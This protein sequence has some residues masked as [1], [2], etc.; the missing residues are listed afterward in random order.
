MTSELSAYTSVESERVKARKW[1]VKILF[2]RL[3]MH[4]RS[5]NECVWNTQ[6]RYRC[7]CDSFATAS[8][9]I[10]MCD[11]LFRPKRLS[12]WCCLFHAFKFQA[13]LQTEEKYNANQAN[14]AAVLGEAEGDQKTLNT[15]ANQNGQ[16]C[17]DM[18]AYAWQSCLMYIYV[19]A[20][21]D[22]EIKTQLRRAC[23]CKTL[24]FQEMNM[25]RGAHDD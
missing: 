8:L 5:L 1:P 24:V 16:G 2:V 21:W 18:A 4:Q 15:P 17:S 9:H 25:H 14:A 10:A 23:L 6:S 19:N 3:S 7:S 20:S 11:V 13:T 22:H 12:S